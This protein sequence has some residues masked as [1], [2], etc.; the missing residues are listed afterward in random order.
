MHYSYDMRFDHGRL[1]DRYPWDMMKQI[2]D[3]LELT[4]SNLDPVCCQVSASNWGK[5][6]RRVIRV[7]MLE[8]IGAGCKVVCYFV[9]LRGSDGKRMTQG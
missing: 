6:H 3:T 7:H 1:I 9:A 8:R 2:G 5:R 4:G